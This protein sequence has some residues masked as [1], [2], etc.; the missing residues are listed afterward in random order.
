[1]ASDERFEIN[2]KSKMVFKIS[3]FIFI[4]ISISVIVS[5]KKDNLAPLIISTTS[6]NDITSSTATVTANIINE[7]RTNLE[8]G[9]CWNTSGNPT[10]D[11]EK[12]IEQGGSG[13]F[14]NIIS[15]L[16]PNTTYFVRSYIKNGITAEY[17]NQLS[18]STVNHTVYY[19]SSKG[20][21][22]DMVS[23]L[24]DHPWKS[25]AYACT[26]VTAPGDVIHISDEITE[27]SQSILPVGV[28][29]EG[30]GTGVSVIKSHVGSPL[31]TIS[32][33]SDN[34]GTDG[35]Q[36]ISNI[37]MDGDNLAGF[38]AIGVDRR[39][40]VEITRCSFV[41]F[42]HY[43]VGFNGKPTG[44]AEGEMPDKYATGNSFHDNLVDNCSGYF[45][46]SEPLKGEGK[47]ALGITGQENMQIY[48]NTLI[49]TK[50]P[51]GSNGFLIKGV[52]GYNKDIKIHNNILT[53]APY[54]N[55]TWDFA[56]EMW[57]SRGGIEIYGNI[58]KGA[59]DLSGDASFGTGVST[60]KGSYEYGA[61]I[62]NN[63][64]GQDS[65]SIYN[66]TYG[67]LIEQSASDVIIEK[68][69]IKNTWIPLYFPLI[70]KNDGT[71]RSL[72]NIRISYNICDQ[73]GQKSGGGSGLPGYGIS[74][75]KEDIGFTCDNVKIWNN[76][77]IAHEGGISPYW[78]I[79]LPS[80]GRATNISV[81]NNIVTGFR[82]YA[83]FGHGQPGYTL[84]NLSVETNIFYRNGVDSV[85]FYQIL[86]TNKIVQ[87]NFSVDPSFVALHDFH[88]SP[89]SPAIDHGADVG[90]TNDFE[91]KAVPFGLFPDIGAYE[92]G[93]AV[94]SV[95]N[96]WQSKAS[97][98]HK[99]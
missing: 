42:D 31:F 9:V 21:D 97:T 1:M 99:Y 77:I 40:N 86:P 8:R 22:G 50:R 23:G 2:K 78:G 94:G 84:D 52:P 75:P 49:Q 89:G 67:I 53:K 15:H 51:A 71:G 82:N 91:A 10:V 70:S 14:K 93:S 39:M 72:T 98:N 62:H 13:I 24:S 18:F 57:M 73:I 7:S 61:W 37:K 43:G 85:G 34:E 17:G 65:L 5:C 81:K 74:F 58:I 35:N 83:V 26:R 20:T 45:P 68:N 46:P 16:N 56:I 4:A 41:D 3:R 33:T 32:L 66:N 11:N 27:T 76:V 6:V 44:I 59:I 79:V 47:Y 80:I 87:N 29:I 55:L 25:L 88:L 95:I 54:D 38:G 96:R 36:H 30:D 48:N 90:L 63:I 64:I 69:Y 28:S 12:I 19:V 92:Y 60:I